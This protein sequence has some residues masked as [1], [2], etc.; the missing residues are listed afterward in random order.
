MQKA[1]DLSRKSKLS[2][3]PAAGPHKAP[4]RKVMWKYSEALA[5][6]LP[7]CYRI[8]SLHWRCVQPTVQKPIP[9]AWF[10]TVL[11]AMLLLPNMLHAI[12]LRAAYCSLPT[13]CHIMLHAIPHPFCACPRP[14]NWSICNTAAKSTFALDGVLPPIELSPS[15]S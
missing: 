2:N 5:T 11:Y 14:H 7:Q 13:C 1:H 12:P 6:S 3:A 15:T 9:I 8:S 4:S 10:C